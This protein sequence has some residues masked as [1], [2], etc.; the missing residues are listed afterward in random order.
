MLAGLDLTASSHEHLLS[1]S[2]LIEEQLQLEVHDLFEAV[3]ES[4]ELQRVFVADISCEGN[5]VVVNEVAYLGGPLW[6][7]K[8]LYQNLHEPRHV[9]VGVDAFASEVFVVEITLW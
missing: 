6:A 7:L 5:A 1:D 4:S 9:V 2:V 8:V 3:V